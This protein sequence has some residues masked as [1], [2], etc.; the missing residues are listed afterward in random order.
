MPLEKVA[1]LILVTTLVAAC[2]TDDGTRLGNEPDVVLTNADPSAYGADGFTFNKKEHIRGP[3]DFMFYY[4]R[5]TLTGDRS[6]Y[7]KTDYW[8]NEP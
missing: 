2:A 3:N 5:C 4:K 8:C 1:L 6:Y 7:S